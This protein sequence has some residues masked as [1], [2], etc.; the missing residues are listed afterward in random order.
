MV[1]KNI[2]FVS[3]L[4]FTA[5]LFLISLYTN[6]STDWLISVL[7]F[8]V[9]FLINFVLKKIIK[10][11]SS[12]YTK[13]Q[14][15]MY[16]ASLYMFLISV[17]V[18]I[19][20]Y[21]SSFEVAPYILIYYTLLVISLF[22]DRRLMTNLFLGL[23]ISVTIIHFT[24]SYNVL[25]QALTFGE[26]FTQFI[27]TTDFANIILRT[28]FFI[29]FYFVCFAIVSMGANLQEKRKEELQKR[30]EVQKDF[31]LIVDELYQI[32]IKAQQA[33]MNQQSATL[34][35]RLAQKF[36]FNCGLTN[37][38]IEN[39]GSFALVHLKFNEINKTH[40][41]NE[42]FNDDEYLL[43]KQ[44]TDLGLIITKRLMLS[45]KAETIAR[46]FVEQTIDD[47]F[48]KEM[49]II[50]DDLNSQI[51]TFAYLYMICRNATPFKRPI[52]HLQ[53]VEIF[54]EKLSVFFNY[55]LMERFL[56]FHQDF[57][58]IYNNI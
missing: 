32:V 52:A 18:Y 42:S 43:L 31:S 20:L 13:Q 58:N 54:K 25:E 33:L 41:T 45:Q 30:K 40:S 38:E 53:V 5:I 22:Q 17:L 23:L 19:R 47:K 1:I 46:A 24:I 21:R 36:A 12:D 6:N 8:P 51:I 2:I 10:E 29:L 15:A 44:Q 4:F 7:C 11:G 50:G 34:T 28:L 26:F 14:G 27:K 56:K 9:T 3:N 49:I 35:K 55:S 57:E 16:I 37:T 39:I 48:I